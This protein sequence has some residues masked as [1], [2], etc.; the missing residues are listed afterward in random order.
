[1]FRKI[2]L[3]DK[4]LF[5]AMVREFYAS[6]AVDHNLPDAYHI[7][8]FDELM[9]T[10]TYLI[11]YIFESD[12]NP[13]GYCLLNKTYQHEAGGIVLWVEELY[14]RPEFRSQGLGSAFFHFLET[15]P[16]SWIRLEVEPDNTA[17]IRLYEKR[18]FAFLP[19]T[20]MYR[21]A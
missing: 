15:E 16:H 13:C 8:A 20:S 4:D 5:L 21:E 9:R 11:C 18:G 2:T 17:A 12:G 7:R 10:D 19:Y 6:D 1:M 14:V 3:Q